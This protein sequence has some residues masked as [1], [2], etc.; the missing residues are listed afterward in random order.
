MTASLSL[1]INEFNNSKNQ[2]IEMLIFLNVVTEQN[3]H[4][5]NLSKWFAEDCEGKDSHAAS[6]KVEKLNSPSR[7]SAL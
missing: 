5:E 3:M 2:E 1:G 7:S 6:S 4:K